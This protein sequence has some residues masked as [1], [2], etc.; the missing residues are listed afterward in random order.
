MS[1]HATI[2]LHLHNEHSVLQRIL[3]VFSRRRMHIQALQ[4]FDV[5]APRPAELQV[6]LSADDATLRELVAQL[7]RVVEV[8]Q[9]WSERTPGAQTQDAKRTL[10]VA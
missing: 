5:Q 2:H 7:T 6:D 1:Q 4:M 3:L 8:T 10:R 9:V